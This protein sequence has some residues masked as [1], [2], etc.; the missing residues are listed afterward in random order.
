MYTW[1]A[2]ERVKQPVQADMYPNWLA[3]VRGNLDKGGFG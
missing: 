3:A 2:Q 1:R